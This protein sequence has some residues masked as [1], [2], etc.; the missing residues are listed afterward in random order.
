MEA[1]AFRPGN[2]LVVRAF[3]PAN[4]LTLIQLV[5]A[6]LAL[7]SLALA[8]PAWL[9][10]RVNQARIARAQ[11][12]AQSIAQAIER[13]ERDFG[14]LPAWVRADDAAR[15][16]ETDAVDILVG[17]GEIPKIGPAADGWTSGR[18][19]MLRNQ[20]IDN[21]PGYGVSSGGG[22]AAWRGP[23]ITAPPNVDPWQ[24]RYMVNVG[25]AASRQGA[26]STGSYTLVVVSAGPNGI[27]ETV[28]SQAP[29][30]FHVGGDDIVVKIR[31]AGR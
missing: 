25:A 19:E 15:G 8:L 28:Y 29:E 10:V 27:M 13:F 31:R 21:G 6:Q 11:G 26:A 30:Q 9:A 23:Y 4:G 5:L 1:Q 2:A 20:L 7:L 17:A 22:V 18:V 3:R 24:N 16:S 12:E 14:F